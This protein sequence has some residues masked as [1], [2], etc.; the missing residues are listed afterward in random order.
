[1]QVTATDL[2]GSDEHEEAIKASYGVT[3]DKRM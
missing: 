2:D 1:M 3:T